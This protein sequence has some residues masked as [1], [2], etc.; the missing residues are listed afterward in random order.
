MLLNLL[1]RDLR[2][3]VDFPSFLHPNFL[4]FNIQLPPVRCWTLTSYNEHAITGTDLSI[5]MGI[6]RGLRSR[7][8]VSDHRRTVANSSSGPSGQD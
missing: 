3:R 6:C 7:P 4:I 5:T 8:L 1:P 2:R